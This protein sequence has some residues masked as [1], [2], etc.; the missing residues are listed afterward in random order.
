MALMPTGNIT[1]MQIATSR[2]G[3]LDAVEDQIVTRPSGSCHASEACCSIGR[4]VFPP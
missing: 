4:C 3:V 1:P 2:F